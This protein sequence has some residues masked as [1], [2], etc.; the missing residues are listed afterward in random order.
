MT[1]WSRS[2]ARS[3]SSGKWWCNVVSQNQPSVQSGRSQTCNLFHHLVSVKYIISTWLT[4]DTRWQVL[5][6]AMAVV[7]FVALLV[8]VPKLRRIWQA[9]RL[10]QVVG[11]TD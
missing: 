10:K 9:S 5:A 2:V 11:A 3:G 1:D 7:V 4:R 6:M 8:V